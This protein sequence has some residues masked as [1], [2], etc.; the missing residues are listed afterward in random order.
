VC[1]DRDGREVPGPRDGFERLASFVRRFGGWSFCK[2]RP[3]C[4]GEHRGPYEFSAVIDSGWHEVESGDLVAAV[5]YV[6][7]FP[8]TLDW[9][10]GHIGID[11]YEP[12]TWIASSV[13]NLIES[14]ALGQSIYGDPAWREA[15]PVISKGRGWGVDVP[16]VAFRDVVP[17]AAEASSPWNRW[18]LNND[19]AVHGWQIAYKS[20]RE[21]H[22]MAWYR[23][24]TGRRIIEAVTGALRS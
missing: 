8:L 10:A 21:E 17:E 4:R 23:G 3:E 16:S 12:E 18:Y 11:V 13:T 7:G 14:C 2:E 5:G 20:S 9:S 6:E 15:V 24:P 22:V 19:V 1:T